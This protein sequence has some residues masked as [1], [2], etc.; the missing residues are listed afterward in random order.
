M[1]LDLRASNGGARAVNT[2][3]GA[4]GL[5]VA[6]GL[7][8]AVGASCILSPHAAGLLAGIT[9]VRSSRDAGVAATRRAS[10]AELVPVQ[11]KSTK[12]LGVGKILVAS[13]D[14]GDENFAEAVVLL[15]DY[16]EKS[17]VGLILNH[18]S[19]VPISSLF[20]TLQAAKR[21]SDP[22]YSGGPVDDTAILAMRRSRASLP[23][24]DHI[25]G[26]VYVISSKTL[27][28][29]TIAEGAGSS[30]FHV[31]LG[32]AGWTNDQLQQ[33]VDA[34]AW[35][36]FQGDADVVFDSDPDTLW[37][38][39]IRRTEEKIAGNVR[40]RQLPALLARA[41]AGAAFSR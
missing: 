9:R 23:D 35:Y 18:R 21:R 34:G 29:K 12:D 2:S 25:F 39:L 26:D 16:D 7:A 32:Y 38:R 15:I 20:E 6:L 41:F 1:A 4:L 14:L 36:V 3:A 11:S 28:E 24:A 31:Y 30:M 5:A 19:D 17:V 8:S 27:L 37:S 40:G 13:R 22:V 33:E 10:P